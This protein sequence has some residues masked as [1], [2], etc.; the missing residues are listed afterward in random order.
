MKAVEEPSGP[1]QEKIAKC[2]NDHDTM[3]K[4]LLSLVTFLLV[5]TPTMAGKKILFYGPTHE[6]GGA[7]ETFVNTQ[8]G[9]DDIGSGSAIWTPNDPD[10]NL[11]W[12]DKSQ[13][14]FAQ[15]DAI[16]IGDAV[17][18][19]AQLW[20]EAILTKERWMPAV[21]SQGNVVLYGGDPN[22][23]DTGFPEREVIMR[24]IIAF[25]ANGIGTGLYIGLSRVHMEE[26]LEDDPTTSA[27]SRLLAPVGDFTVVDTEAKVVVKVTSHSTLDCIS[28]SVMTGWNFS[29]HQGFLDW[30]ETFVP[31]AIVTDIEPALWSNPSKM[32]PGISG[33]AFVLVRGF[34]NSLHVE[35]S[36][37]CRPIGQTHSLKAVLK[38]ATGL[39]IAGTPVNL[40]ISSGPNSGKSFPSQTT[41]AMGTATWTYVGNIEGQDILKV[42]ADTSTGCDAETT[43][44]VNWGSAIYFYT[45]KYYAAET[46]DDP[47]AT[48]RVVRIGPPTDSATAML[49]ISG[50][51]TLN[52][53][54]FVDVETTDGPR[55]TRFFSVDFE[56]GEQTK[57]ITVTAIPDQLT[58]EAETVVLG[59]LYDDNSFLFDND[60]C[61][62]L[63]ATIEIIP[64]PNTTFGPG[65]VDT[66]EDTSFPGLL[67]IQRNNNSHSVTLNVSFGGTA[68]FG[69]DYYVVIPNDPEP[70]TGGTMTLN[71]GESQKP[72]LIYPIA[73]T[74]SELPYETVQIVLSPLPG[75]TFFGPT[76]VTMAINDDDPVA[77]PVNGYSLIDLGPMGGSV[78]YGLGINTVPQGTGWRGDVVGFAQ[79]DISYNNSIMPFRGFKWSNGSIIYPNALPW[80]GTR[81][82]GQPIAI[83]DHGTVVGAYGYYT[84]SSGY[85]VPTL[86]TPCYWPPG[87]TTPVALHPIYLASLGHSASDIN[88]RDSIHGGTIVGWSKTEGGNTHAAF[89]AWTNSEQRYDIAVDLSDLANGS[90]HSFAMAINDSGVTVGRSQILTGNNYHG[91]RT[92]TSLN[93]FGTPVPVALDEVFDDMGTATGVDSDRSEFQDINKHGEIVGLGT[94]ASGQIRALYKASGTGKNQGYVDLGVLGSGSDAGNE[95]V[96][97]SISANGLIVGQSRVKEGALQV[98]RA[99]VVSNVGNPGSQPMQDLNVITSIYVNSSWQ[100]VTSQGWKLISAER[101]NRAGWIAGYGTKSGLTRAFVLAPR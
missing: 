17:T 65:S 1:N 92:R 99:F 82:W 15:F 69:K 7:G 30:P 91:F 25:V 88:Q 31:L 27:I 23:H 6:P 22:F 4:W 33:T 72:I 12:N 40:T 89:W 61:G 75:N 48:F 19:N 18:P 71:I 73:D 14:D 64:V 59:F 49:T 70:F 87:S 58:E 36:S 85:W 34:L 50:T 54:Y 80:I 39:P 32:P 101:V 60:Y 53:D 8:P 100:T 41:D 29:S 51:A 86:A 98:W 24:Q 66:I 77:L 9:Y 97:N 47:N 76:V 93:D 79:Q 10:P 56:P 95:S 38:D 5:C 83:N 45:E 96:A 2:M 63:S 57:V 67:V 74:R 16:I 11:D 90:K 43:S 52:E 55:G 3:R 68:T 84:S 81:P 44:H 37:H 26:T 35:T 28:T 21:H 62:P 46:G 94:T 42:T 13:A 78:A 20:E